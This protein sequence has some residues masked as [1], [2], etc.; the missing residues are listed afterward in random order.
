[1]NNNTIFPGAKIISLGIQLKKEKILVLGDF[2]I[3]QEEEL[4][5][6]GIMMP[7]TN[8]SKLKKELLEIFSKTGKL[9]K[10]ILLGDI[11]HEFGALNNQE[12]KEVVELI[13]ILEKKSEKL[14]II[15][16]NHDNFLKP[17]TTWKK[18]ELVDKII[19]GKILLCHGDKIISTKESEKTKYII[20]GHEHPAITLKDEHKSEK[21][22]CFIKT[23]YGKGIHKKQ[24]IVMP[25]L[26]FLTIG[27]DLTKEK[28]I[29]PYL[30]G[31]NTFE[32]WIVE[33]AQS[34]YFGKI[35]TLY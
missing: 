1:M 10:I 9:K 11:K 24:L 22:K 33:E 29:S 17:I 31:M 14:I 6:Q 18:I 3:G 25:S 20:I 27:T 7:R 13:E 30:K 4:N 12:W 21:F 34:F 23:F 8:F 5:K 28:P 26:N 19:I 16:G 15:K 35:K 2:H 32:C